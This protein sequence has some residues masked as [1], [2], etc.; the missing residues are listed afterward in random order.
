M[1]AVQDATGALLVCF[2]LLSN[3]EHSPECQYTTYRYLVIL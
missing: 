2:N 1:A 3:T